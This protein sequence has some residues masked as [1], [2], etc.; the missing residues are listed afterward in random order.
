MIKEF[1]DSGLPRPV[2]A[3]LGATFA[4]D[5]AYAQ[6]WKY[7]TKA[8]TPNKPEDTK[9]AVWKAYAQSA[10]ALGY[11]KETIQACDIL[12]PTEESA[13]LRAVLLHRKAKA[14]LGLRQFSSANTVAKQALELKPQG[15]LNAELRLTMG[16]IA[17][18]QDDLDDA[19][20]H[21]VVV[22]EI[23]GTGDNKTAAIKRAIDVYQEKGDSTSLAAAAKYKA[24]LK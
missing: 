13:Y 1:P 24:L 15:E 9:K 12:L 5:G 17:L 3:W 23:I 20:S 8:V 4:A 18:K 19:L 11:H 16:D 10:E 21:Y 2:Y 14:L 22:A 6:A 7:L